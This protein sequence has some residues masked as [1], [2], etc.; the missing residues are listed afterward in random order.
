MALRMNSHPYFVVKMST[1][2]E[3]AALQEARL[4]LIYALVVAMLLGIVASVLLARHITTDISRIQRVLDNIGGGDFAGRLDENRQ[5]EIGDISRSTNQLAG[6]LEDWRS[7]LVEMDYVNGLNTQLQTKTNLLTEQKL[8]IESRQVELEAA[9]SNL[10]VAHRSM[11][12]YLECLDAA[13]DSILIID[14]RGDIQYVNPYCLQQNGYDSDYLLGRSL[15]L[16]MEA[17]YG[18]ILLDNIWQVL[19][20]SNQWKAELTFTTATHEEYPVEA[21][22]TRVTGVES[23]ES[24]PETD[25]RFIVIFRDISIR[26]KF[27]AELLE[28]ANHDALTGLLNRRSFETTIQ[29]EIGVHRHKQASFSVMWLDLDRFKEVNDT[30]GHQVGDQLLIET[31]SLMGEALRVM[32][33][34]GR[35]GGDEFAFVLPHTNRK[36]AGLVA[37]KLLELIREYSLSLDGESITVGGSFGVALYPKDGETVDAL[38]KASDIA[39][40]VAKRQG[41]DQVCFY[42]SGLAK[43]G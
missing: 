8:E 37:N 11:S 22:I 25:Q 27:E 4:D 6:K 21:T 43:M 33:T 9:V 17:R 3:T 13:H 20:Y 19:Q 38:L 24:N 1:D 42:N 16:L 39:M 32:D 29:R 41:R 10:E 35:M 7:Q 18:R 5:D 36:S 2:D 26:V 15:D 28:V 34:I 40:Y 23:K 30:Y 12:L 31:T 14:R